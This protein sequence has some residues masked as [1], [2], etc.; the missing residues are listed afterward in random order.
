MAWDEKPKKD[1][2]TAQAYRHNNSV[3]KVEA[4][5]RS[6]WHAGTPPNEKRAAQRVLDALLEKMGFEEAQEIKQMAIHCILSDL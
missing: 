6:I 1:K 3:V 5:L 2:I 4:L